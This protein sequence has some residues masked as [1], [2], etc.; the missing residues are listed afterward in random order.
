HG[1]AP[2]PRLTGSALLQYAGGAVLA[3]EH[4]MSFPARRAAISRPKTLAT[5]PWRF[6]LCSVTKLRYAT[7]RTAPA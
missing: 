2:A 5:S 3:V 6:V 1:H 7:R 4:S